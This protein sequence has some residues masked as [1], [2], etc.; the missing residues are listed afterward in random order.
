M[1]RYVPLPGRTRYGIQPPSSVL[2]ATAYQTRMSSGRGSGEPNAPGTGSGA[3]A[4]WLPLR[5]S[6][7]AVR[8]RPVDDLFKPAHAINELA[9]AA[10]PNQLS[11]A[12][13]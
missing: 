9:E 7:R 2:F 12:L 8:L 4:G 13:G 1:S 3:Y 5:P 11:C 10:H 6:G